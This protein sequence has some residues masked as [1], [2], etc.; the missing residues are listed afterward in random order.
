MATPVEK[1]AVLQP[2]GK[3]LH[4]AFDAMPM[5]LRL[6]LLVASIIDAHPTGATLPIKSLISVATLM[7]SKLSPAQQGELQDHMRLEASSLGARL[8]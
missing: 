2:R 3:R 8:N 6:T 7:G 4:S 5:D 1:Y